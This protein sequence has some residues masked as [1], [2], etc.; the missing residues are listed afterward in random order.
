MDK[1]RLSYFNFLVLIL[2]FKISKLYL[3]LAKFQNYTPVVYLV[4]EI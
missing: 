3:K 2:F 1:Y 4:D